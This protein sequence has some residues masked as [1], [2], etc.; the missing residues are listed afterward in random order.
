[1]VLVRETVKSNVDMDIPFEAGRL[2]DPL[3]RSH[4]ERLIFNPGS[5]ALGLENASIRGLRFRPR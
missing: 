5:A 2:L 4:I 1:M 3:P